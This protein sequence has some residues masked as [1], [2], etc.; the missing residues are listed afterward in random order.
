MT[1]DYVYDSKGKKK[2]VIIPIGLWEKNK[3]KI[4]PETHSTP[5]KPFKPA[6]YRGLFQKKEINL[7]KEA[8]K[9]NDEWVR[10]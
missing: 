5:K 2:G 9:L 3:A 6:H 4:L 10:K 8:S 7:K 1:I